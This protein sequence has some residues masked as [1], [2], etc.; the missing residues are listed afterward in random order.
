M[1][2]TSKLLKAMVCVSQ[3]HTLI[4]A[5]LRELGV[6]G[7]RLTVLF[8]VLLGMILVCKKH[9]T[10]HQSLYSAND[11]HILCSLPNSHLTPL[12]KTFHIRTY[13]ATL[14]WFI[15]HKCKFLTIV[16]LSF[17]G[18][19]WFTNHLQVSSKPGK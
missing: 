19:C 14:W 3:T 10:C 5:A 13:A 11:P 7:E 18:L 6:L 9:R 8:C 15:N 2:C 17:A 12:A 16:F 4:K 1:S